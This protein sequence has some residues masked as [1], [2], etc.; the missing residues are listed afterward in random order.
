MLILAQFSPQR[1]C[2]MR[3]FISAINLAGGAK[4]IVKNRKLLRGKIFILT[5][6]TL[7][8][9]ETY[10]ASSLETIY[11]FLLHARKVVFCEGLGKPLYQ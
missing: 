9:E 5:T 3:E 2:G 7:L 6:E 10:R 4:G 8:C 11:N 1:N